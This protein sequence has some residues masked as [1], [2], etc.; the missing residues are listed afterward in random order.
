MLSHVAFEDFHFGELGHALVLFASAPLGNKENQKVNNFM[1]HI[2]SVF[3]DQ[4]SRSVQ[5]S[6]FT[7]KQIKTKVK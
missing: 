3:V 7:W 5:N 6:R 1:V 2:Y 4:N